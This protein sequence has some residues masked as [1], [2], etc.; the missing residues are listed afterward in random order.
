[1]IRFKGDDILKVIM[2]EKLRF[3]RKSFFYIFKDIIEINYLYNLMF[4]LNYRFMRNLHKNKLVY[5]LSI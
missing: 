3:I 2:R 1:M 4:I 5:K